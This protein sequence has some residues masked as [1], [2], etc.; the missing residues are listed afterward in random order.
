MQNQIYIRTKGKI[1]NIQEE[2]C[3]CFIEEIAR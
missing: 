1:V 2:L 3:N